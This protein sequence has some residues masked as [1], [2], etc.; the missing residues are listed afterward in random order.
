MTY[1]VVI[2]VFLLPILVWL[3][4]DAPFGYE[5]VRMALLTTPVGAAMS[6][7]EAPGFQQYNLLP[8]AWWIA[9]VASLV[10]FFVL[11]VQVWRLTRAV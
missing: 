6:V 10:M 3:A 2:L 1:V 4:R 9:G 11:G 5:T 8:A 7:I